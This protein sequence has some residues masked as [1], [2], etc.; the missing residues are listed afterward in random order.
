MMVCL[1]APTCAE[2]SCIA[3]VLLLF[4]PSSVILYQ[5]ALL[6]NLHW[7]LVD[8]GIDFK[9]I[10]YYLI[11]SKTSIILKH[12]HLGVYET[13]SIHVFILGLG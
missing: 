8:L 3:I 10:C 9:R 12:F 2:R 1:K 13:A 11:E 4:C 6:V 7:N 5:P